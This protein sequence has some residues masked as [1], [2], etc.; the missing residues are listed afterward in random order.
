LGRLFVISGKVRNGYAE[1]RSFIRVKGAIY[2]KGGTLLQERI[3]YCGNVVPDER[4]QALEMPEIE[5]VLSNRFGEKK[6]NFRVGSGTDLPFM[7]V[8][9]NPQ[10]QLGE[11]S[12]EVVD[13]MAE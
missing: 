11:Y 4:L 3:A 6:S 7:V 13:S 10:Q 1:P 12:V 8:F 2:S 9:P 5:R